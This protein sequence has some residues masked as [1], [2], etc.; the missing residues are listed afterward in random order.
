MENI[1]GRKHLQVKRDSNHS[2]KH[3][4]VLRSRTDSEPEKPRCEN[5]EDVKLDISHVSAKGDTSFMSTCSSDINLT[6]SSVTKREIRPLPTEA[7]TSMSEQTGGDFI[8]SLSS[9]AEV[10]SESDQETDSIFL[11]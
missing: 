4:M 6:P 9:T 5:N 7:C 1:S 11:S 3:N 10:D 8:P 2:A